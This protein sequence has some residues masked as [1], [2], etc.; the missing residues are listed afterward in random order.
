MLQSCESYLFFGF[1]VFPFARLLFDVGY[2]SE[3]RSIVTVGKVDDIGDGRQH[4]TLAACPNRSVSLTHCQQEL[5]RS[6]AR[7]V[8]KYTFFC[9]I[10]RKP[11]LWFNIY[12]QDKTCSNIFKAYL[13]PL[14]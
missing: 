10:S 6:T 4:S 2:H 13:S 5:R 7:T 14:H 9:S 3:R 11:S 8:F 12:Q 1:A